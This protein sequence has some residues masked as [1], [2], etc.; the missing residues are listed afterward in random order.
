MKKAKNV[1][2][3]SLVQIPTHQFASHRSGWNG[4]QFEKAIVT[5]QGKTKDGEKVW[6]VEYPSH[7]YKEDKATIVKWMKPQYMFETDTWAEM[8]YLEY[9][10]EEIEDGYSNTVEFFIDKGIIK[11]TAE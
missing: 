1:K 6:Q 2:V 8:Q 7:S 5:K 4:W 10:R 3:G 9:S 11:E